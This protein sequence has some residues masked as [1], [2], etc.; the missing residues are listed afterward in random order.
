KGEEYGLDFTKKWKDQKERLTFCNNVS[1]QPIALGLYARIQIKQRTS[2]NVYIII[3]GE[4]MARRALAFK[5]L[6][7]K[8]EPQITKYNTD[9]LTN[10]LMD[11]VI[12]SSELSDPCKAMDEREQFSKTSRRRSHTLRVQR[13]K[14]IPNWAAGGENEEIYS[15]EDGNDG[16][17]NGG[18]RNG[19]DKASGKRLAS[20][21]IVERP[22]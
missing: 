16:G 18:G 14:G 11:N 4:K 3:I 8:K 15:S 19:D 17:E 2:M 21:I 5:Y 9:E 10:L 22:I 1:N 20:D 7:R 12:Y 6:Y 13:P